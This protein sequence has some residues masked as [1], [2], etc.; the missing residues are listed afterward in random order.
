[1]TMLDA[2]QHSTLARLRRTFA[3]ERVVL[4]GASALAVHLPLMRPTNDVDIV[5]LIDASD[6]EHRLSADGWEQDRKARHRW[7]YGNE[8]ADVLAIT[9]ASLAAGYVQFSNDEKALSIIGFDV[10][11]RDAELH[12]IGGLETEV[13]VASLPSLVLLKIVAW[14]DRPEEREKDL[15]DLWLILVS[16][17]SDDD[18]LRWPEEPSPISSRPHDE[19]SP[20]LVGGELRQV[21]GASHAV[22]VETFF[23]RLLG[24]NDH[25]LL[26][27][28]RITRQHSEDDYERVRQLLEVFRAGFES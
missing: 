19:Q 12:M 9:D 25:A 7:R 8:I 28:L 2:I 22:I 5:V 11:L 14:L 6:A 20:Y 4:I 23:A 15:A 10:A 17:L 1:M 21:C 24:E 3:S 26:T 13:H 18:D 16:R 27:L